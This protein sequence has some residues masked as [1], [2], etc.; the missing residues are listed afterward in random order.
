MKTLLRTLLLITLSLFLFSCEDACDVQTDIDKLKTERTNL[1]NEVNTKN[2]T[3]SQLNTTIKAKNESLKE[4]DI[5]MCQYI[6]YILSGKHKG[7]KKNAKIPYSKLKQLGFKPLVN[8]FWKTRK[9]LE[10][11]VKK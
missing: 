5:Y 4:I 2:N 1:E 10:F 8:E 6:R 9:S 7:Y 3:I 11:S